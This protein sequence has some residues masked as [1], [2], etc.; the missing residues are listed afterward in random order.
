[1]SRRK[2]GVRC[3]LGRHQN[4]EPSVKPNNSCSYSQPTQEGGRSM[5]GEP[6][7]LSWKHLRLGSCRSDAHPSI[8]P[9]YQEGRGTAELFISIPGGRRAGIHEVG[10]EEGKDDALTGWGP[11]RAD[12]RA[13]QRMERKISTGKMSQTGCIPCRRWRASRKWGC[14][15]PTAGGWGRI[16][17]GCSASTKWQLGCSLPLELTAPTVLAPWYPVGPFW[18]HTGARPGI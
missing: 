13:R 12:Q 2:T 6:F 18:N 10:K 7:W 4:A 17:L 11:G 16:S 5:S 8:R 15:L 14:P 1:M 3:Q 9:C